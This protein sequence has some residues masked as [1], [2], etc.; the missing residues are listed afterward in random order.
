MIGRTDITT[1]HDTG[2]LVVE[3]SF[4][5][6]PA[7]VW[8]CWTTP[9]IVH[10]WGPRRW[11]AEIHEMDV[12][13]GGR[14]RYT[15]APESPDE[16]PTTHC[17]ALYQRVDAPRA[18]RFLDGF[19]DD[20]GAL[21][22]GATT[23]TAVD[24]L[25]IPGG[26]HLTITIT[27]PDAAGLARALDL[28]MV[29]G[30][31]DTLERLDDH[32]RHLE[33]ST[34]M[35]RTTSADGTTIAYTTQGSG[36]ALVLVNT[37]LEDHHGYDAIAAALAPSFAVTRYDRRG[38]GESGDTPPYAPEREVEDIAA[39]IDAIGGSAALA[40][41]SG[42]CTLALDAASALGRAVT[43][44]YLYE[45]PFIVSP[46]QPIP[47]ADWGERAA[48]LVAEGDR[49]GAVELF[50]SQV[51]GLPPEYLEP[52]KAD[53]SWAEMERWAHTLPYDAAI[54]AGT[55]EG[56]PLPTDR[57]KVDQPTAVVVGEGSPPF[58]HDAAK[59]LVELLG[60]ATCSTLPGHD[61]SAFW[62]APDALVESITAA[63]RR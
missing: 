28:G 38:R 60:D 24:F 39:V 59:A 20:E 50:F 40:A 58:F 34:A 54:A 15:L 44:L 45:P 25:A 26:T 43:G 5:A 14:W 9:E 32:L 63:L 1:R 46:G 19:T 53:G 16:G 56:K 49:R 55:Q 29:E 13:P 35:E 30:M 57:W 41:G 61:H 10:W 51:M 48:A 12:R 22:D 42:G 27:Y 11:R 23:P 36:P 8:R 6:R 21:V 62:M 17:L 47:P 2:E 3:R 33:G 52:M 7:T 4:A 18:L 37:C 31:R